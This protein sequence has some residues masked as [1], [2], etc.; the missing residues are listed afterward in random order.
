MWKLF[1][2]LAKL[3]YLGW[4]SRKIYKRSVRKSSSKEN[5]IF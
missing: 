2:C 3:V 5:I 4:I 1:T